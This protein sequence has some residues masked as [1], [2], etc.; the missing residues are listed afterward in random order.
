MKR[1]DIVV[2]AAP[3]DFGKPRPVL[4][5]Q[6]D[7]FNDSHSSVVVCLISSTLSDAP[8]FRVTVEPTAEN[9]LKRRSQ[10][11][12]DRVVALRR[13]RFGDAIGHLD[14]D[15]ML[16]VNRALAMWLGLAD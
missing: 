16:R 2:A 3:G 15:T 5:V 4:V 12:I 11:M 9:G 7:F 10:V 8:L 14:A 1:G 6:S 13:E